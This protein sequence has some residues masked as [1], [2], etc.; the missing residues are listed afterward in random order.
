MTFSRIDSQVGTR[1]RRRGGGLT[2]GWWLDPILVSLSR[3]Y[4]LG[5]QE[6]P[7]ERFGVGERPGRRVEPDERRLGVR[8]FGRNIPVEHEPPAGER[9]G[10]VDW[11]VAGV[12]IPARLSARIARSAP[13]FHPAHRGLLY[14]RP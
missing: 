13:C 11:I 8:N 12:A 5:A 10:D 7:G 6:Q 4:R 14:S 2:A 3:G 9:V 1:K